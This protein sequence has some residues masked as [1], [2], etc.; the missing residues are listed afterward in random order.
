[1]TKKNEQTDGKT[2]RATTGRGKTI[3]PAIA[4]GQNSADEKSEGAGIQGSEYYDPRP[5][6]RRNRGECD[7][8]PINATFG[9]VL[10]HLANLETRFYKYVHAH[11]ERLDLRRKESSESER[12]F[13]AEAEELRA[14]ILGIIG[15]LDPKELKPELDEPISKTET[16]ENP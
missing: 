11:Q 2:K 3:D 4:R 6:Q 16:E 5:S 10:E 15:E 8:K 13:A 12:E 9:E 7:N 14:K 1:M